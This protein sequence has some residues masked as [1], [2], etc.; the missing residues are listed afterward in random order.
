M[1]GST[2]NASG[3]RPPIVC[4]GATGPAP[5]QVR[6]GSLGPLARPF[7]KERVRLAPARVPLPWAD[8][9][10]LAECAQRRGHGAALLRAIY[11][12][13]LGRGDVTEITVEDLYE[14]KRFE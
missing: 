9:G 10:A 8:G 2:S 4:S 13:V 5:A 11:S 7:R 12:D 6:C 3:P 14:W 1:L